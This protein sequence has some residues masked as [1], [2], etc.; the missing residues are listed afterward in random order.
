MR[1]SLTRVHQVLSIDAATQALPKPQ[2]LHRIPRL[3]GL[4]GVAI[5]AVLLRHLGFA[6]P[7]NGVFDRVVSTVL[8]FGWSGV[9]LFFVLSGFLITGILFEKRFLLLKDRFAA[10]VVGEERTPGEHLLDATNVR[11]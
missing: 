3:D 11:R 5:L 10:R 2:Y 8:L 1:V 7:V 6:Y 4:R 9:D